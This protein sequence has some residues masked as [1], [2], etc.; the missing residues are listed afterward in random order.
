[1]KVL[2]PLIVACLFISTANSQSRRISKARYER[3][4][5]LAISK[6]NDAYPV[7]FKVT[8]NFIENGK[9]IRT[10][11]DFNENESGA[12]NRLKRTTISE[13]RRTNQYQVSPGADMNFCSDDG[14]SWKTTKNQCFG[15]VSIYGPREVET[16]EY[17]VR[18]KWVKRKRVNVYLEYSVFAPYEGEQKREFQERVSTIDSR[19]F[20]TTVVDT[21]GTLTPKKVTLRRKQYWVTNARIK[22]VV[23]PIGN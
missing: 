22:P 17:S 12:R 4:I 6:T 7:V 16:S 8:T 23:P 10:V 11:I 2:L 1:M 5:K 14:V 13:G 3:V 20:F 19:G 15:P 21:E 9:I 18:T